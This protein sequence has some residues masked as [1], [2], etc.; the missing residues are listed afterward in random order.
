MLGDSRNA[1]HMLEAFYTQDKQNT[2]SR[3][4]RGAKLKQMFPWLNP[5]GIE[6]ASYS[7]GIS[8]KLSSKL[9]VRYI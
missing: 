7:L 9:I 4:Y 6:L 8:S 5:D 2:K 3:L 1:P